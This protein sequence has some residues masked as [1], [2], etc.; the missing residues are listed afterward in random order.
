MVEVF[1]LLVMAW[2]MYKAI[3]YICELSKYN[4]YV[5]THTGTKLYTR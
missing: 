2:V 4:N 5:E 1:L 3:D